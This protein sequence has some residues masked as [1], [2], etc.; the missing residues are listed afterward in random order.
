MRQFEEAV[1]LASSMIYVQNLTQFGK[2]LQRNTLRKNNLSG[3]SSAGI[4]HFS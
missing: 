2:F 3:G 4:A 1:F